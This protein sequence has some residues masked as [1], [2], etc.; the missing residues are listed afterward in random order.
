MFLISLMFMFVCLQAFDFYST[1]KV[2]SAGGVELNPVI[3]FLISKT[4]LTFALTVTKLIM[5]P[6]VVFIAYWFQE[7]QK[8][9]WIA[10]TIVNAFYIYVAFNNYAVMK[11]MKLI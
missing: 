1:L 2:V 9:L 6:L 4:N 3:S 10:F 7:E 11:A 8:T 5:I